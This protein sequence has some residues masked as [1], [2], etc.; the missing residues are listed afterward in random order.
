MSDVGSEDTYSPPL[1]HGIGKTVTLSAGQ[2]GSKQWW[3]T[4]NGS[5]RSAANHR[6]CLCAIHGALRNDARN[7]VV[8]V[9]WADPPDASIPQEFHAG[10]PTVA[11]WLNL[12]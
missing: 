2:S 11:D 1:R 4:K 9:H 5:G 7:D 6:V 3:I 12:T 8:V 10:L